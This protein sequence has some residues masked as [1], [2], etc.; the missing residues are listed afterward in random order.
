[1]CLLSDSQEK[2]KNQNKCKS[3]DVHIYQASQV[4]SI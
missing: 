1:M 4:E 2:F 3:E